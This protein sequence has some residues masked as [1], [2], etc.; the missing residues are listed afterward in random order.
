MDSVLAV[1]VSSGEVPYADATLAD[2][3]STSAPIPLDGR[4]DEVGADASPSGQSD[5]SVDGGPALDG[6]A[7]D[8]GEGNSTEVGGVDFGSF[9][10]G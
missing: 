7:F 9:E 10:S 8:G 5:L 2:G 4:L 6:S 1:E 3:G